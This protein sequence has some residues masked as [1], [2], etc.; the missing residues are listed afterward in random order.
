MEKESLMISFGYS[1]HSNLH[2]RSPESP[3]QKCGSQY[4]AKESEAMPRSFVTIRNM[5]IYSE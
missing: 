4:H 2:W 3:R 1:V 5:L